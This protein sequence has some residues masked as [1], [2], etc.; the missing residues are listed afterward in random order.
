MSG[1]WGNNFEH[2]MDFRN[3]GLGWFIIYDILK[4]LIV[5]AIV[6]F[7]AKMFIKHFNGNQKIDENK[8]IT[9][10]KERYAS[11]EITEEEY[12]KMLERLKE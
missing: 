3:N 12:R 4:L 11:G 6:I 9:I 8:A 7:V 5:A 2:M 10:L 1:F